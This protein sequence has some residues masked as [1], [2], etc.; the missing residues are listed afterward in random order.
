[1]S[2]TSITEIRSWETPWDDLPK[3]LAE[4]FSD[5]ER[6]AYQGGA[7]FFKECIERT[8]EP[9]LAELIDA[10]DDDHPMWVYVEREGHAPPEI[11]FAF[12]YLELERQ[13]QFMLS[14]DGVC[15]F[16]LPRRLE[17]FYEVFGGLRCGQ[18]DRGGLRFPHMMSKDEIQPFSN[19]VK[20][21]EPSRFIEFFSFGNGDVVAYGEKDGTALLFDHETSN[22]LAR[23]LDEFLDSYFAELVRKIDY[24]RH[25]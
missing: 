15:P 12:T 23:G 18:D 8:N 7:A 6:V 25:M 17:L 9:R 10:L 11:W 2:F 21:F 24:L 19:S 16:E 20:A 13:P 14:R 5:R 4:A 1:M 22:V 3:E